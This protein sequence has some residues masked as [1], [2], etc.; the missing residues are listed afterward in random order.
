MSVLLVFGSRKWT[1][2]API[3]AC[4]AGARKYG[5]TRV[6]H[7]GCEGAD[8]IA[9]EADLELGW[10]RHEVIVFPADWATHGKAAGPLRNRAMLDQAHPTFARG[11]VLDP[12]NPSNG[13]AD[14]YQRCLSAGIAVKLLGPSA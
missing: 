2:R 4:L 8:T 14:M 6:V 1:A 10:P 7:G 13:S 9:D 5:V 11:F 3:E 12:S